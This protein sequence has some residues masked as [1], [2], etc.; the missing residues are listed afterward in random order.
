[1]T[2]IGKGRNMNYY[3]VISKF[4]NFAF[5]LKWLPTLTTQS[6]SKYSKAIIVLRYLL[7]LK[8]GSENLVP[9][10]NLFMYMKS[11]FFRQNQLFFI[12]RIG[13]KFS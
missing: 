8:E 12:V 4:K 9:L 3:L 5:L 7:I 6:N 11:F 1:M 13:V 2:V 10:S